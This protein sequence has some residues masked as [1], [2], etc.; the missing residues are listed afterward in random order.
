MAPIM[1]IGGLQKAMN[2]APDL[3]WIIALAVFVLF[4]VIA[5][6][7]TIAVPRFKKLQTLVDKL[8]LVARENLVGLKVIR[9]FHNEKIEQKKFQKANT[10][11]NKMNLF[12]NRLMM[13][14]DPIMALVMNFSSVAIV[15]FGAHLISGGNLQIGNMMAFLEYAMQVIIS[16]L[17]L[18]M[19]LPYQCVES[20]KFWIQCRQLLTRSRR[21]NCQ[22]TPREKLNLRTLRLLILTRI[23]QCFRILIL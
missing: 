4:V 5:T 8:N 22:K 18:S 17:L 10:E 16:F 21:K 2:N 3:S 7:F 20:E 9:A 1:A 15:W 14:L 19:V 6:L 13:L 11:L 12:V 23:C